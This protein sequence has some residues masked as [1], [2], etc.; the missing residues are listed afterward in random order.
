[1]HPRS[2]G[3]YS[4]G[5]WKEIRKEWP[6]MKSKIVFS[7]GDGKKVR[8]WEDR[9]YGDYALSISFPS[10]YALATSKEA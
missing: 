2:K 7:E 6:L 10:L 3:R 9:W 1:M 5:F 8:F 4:V